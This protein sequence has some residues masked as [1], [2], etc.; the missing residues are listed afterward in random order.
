MHSKQNRAIASGLVLVAVGLTLYLSQTIEGV[1]Q[2]IG[3]VLGAILVAGYFYTRN[4]GFLVPGCI[5]LTLGL[6]YIGEQRRLLDFDRGSLI[7]LGF[8]F[9][10]IF[11]IQFAYERKAHWWPLVPGAILLA[12]AFDRFGEWW[13]L[14]LQNWPLLLVAAGILVIVSAFFGKKA[15]AKG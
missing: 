6:G 7:P 2:Y 8:A 9:I 1:G 5:F 14:L 13:G 11:V 12:V 4:Y 15:D 10:A 3:A